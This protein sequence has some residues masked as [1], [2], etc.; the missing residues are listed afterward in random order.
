MITSAEEQAA[1]VKSFIVGLAFQA[2]TTG[3]KIGSQNS[4]L[5]G[6]F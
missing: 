3:H 6:K 4:P 1:Y 5:D 2:K